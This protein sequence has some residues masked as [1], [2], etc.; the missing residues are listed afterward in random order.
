MKSLASIPQLGTGISY[1]P[2]FS[3]KVF[4]HKAEI[5]F[6]EIVAD[7]YLDASPE[8]WHEL[9]VLNDHFV[10]IPHAINTSLGS[11][12]APDE[13][14]VDKLASL[15]EFIQPPYWSEHI[16]FSKINNIEIGH[17]SPLPHT[18]ASIETI[19]KNIALVQKKIKTPLILENISYLVQQPMHQMKEEEFIRKIIQE[20]GCGLLLDLTNLVYNA[21]NH[22]YKEEDF[23][24]TLPLD[25]VIQFHFTGGIFKW[26]RWIDNHAAPTPPEVWNLMQA[27]TERC[28]VRGAVLERDDNHPDWNILLEDLRKASTFMKKNNTINSYR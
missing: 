3:S 11:A 12:E 17:L 15:I 16:S 19:C 27:L 8:K 22:Q 21:A 6:L 1:R 26:G 13:S 18:D 14:Y 25:S 7:H 23:L 9:Q 5:D 10:L 20:S 2:H 28:N 4:Q 24:T